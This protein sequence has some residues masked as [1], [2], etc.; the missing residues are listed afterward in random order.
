MAANGKYLFAANSNQI[1]IESYKIASDGSIV[2]ESTAN[3]SKVSDCNDSGPLFVGR[4]GVSLYDLEIN[5]ISCVNNTYE[6]FTVDPSNGELKNMGNSTANG[7]LNLPASFIGDNT[8]AYSAV[9]VQDMFWGIY[10][11]H[12]HPNGLLTEIN[13]DGAPPTPP[14]GYFYCPSQT[15][16][17]PTDHVAISMQPINQ[18]DFLPDR[19]AQLA[20][21]KAD[22]E[23]NL[24]TTSTRENMPET[25][26]GAVTDLVMSPGG[27][28]LAV[29]GTGGLQVFHFNG[30]DPV[31]HY[32]GLLTADKIDQFFWDKDEHLYA[33]SRT[34]G[35][36]F[37]FSISTTSYRQAPGSP[38]TISLPR[39]IAVQP[40]P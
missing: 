18:E 30:S 40:L 39:N 5:G 21:F 12:R 2:Y 9:C 36:L 27:K 33:I 25:A 34:A 38:Y 20:T 3:I 8:F 37:V 15:A 26:V 7:W 31:T 19:P 6:S 29:G 11:F 1:E 10:G 14:D 23:G 32:T 13:I 16:T 22:G 35:K 4:D 28:F 17:D 24:T